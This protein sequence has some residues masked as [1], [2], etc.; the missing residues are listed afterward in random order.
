MSRNLLMLCSL[1]LLVVFCTGREAN[2]QNALEQIRTD[3]HYL[4]SRISEGAEG[5]DLMER[6]KKLVDRY[7]TFQENYPQ[8]KK[9]ADF[10]FQAGMLSA[11]M[12]GEFEDGIRLLKN[13]QKDYEDQ[14]IAEQA[15]FMAG[16]LY[17]YEIGDHDAAQEVYTRFLEIYPDSDMAEG[18][19][20]AYEYSGKVADPDA[21]QI[22]VTPEDVH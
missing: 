8:H 15:L 2:Q 9:S 10:L 1:T 11:E 14:L 13:V 7:V 4:Q 17:D 20:Q 5:Q 6:S 12:H 3:E 16:F 21:P 19:Q 22:P 18:V